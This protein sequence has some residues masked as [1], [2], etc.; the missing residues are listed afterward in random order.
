MPRSGLHA[1]A[2]AF[3]CSMPSMKCAA[4]PAPRTRHARAAPRMRDRSAKAKK[5]M[6][7]PCALPRRA[8]QGPPAWIHKPLVKE[9]PRFVHK[10]HQGEATK[11]AE[12]YTKKMAGAHVFHG[13][14]GARRRRASR[15]GR[16]VFFCARLRT[17]LLPP[18][19]LLLDRRRGLG[20]RAR[21]GK[22]LTF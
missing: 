12:I 11:F 2:M 13:G 19:L 8:L 9:N 10:L 1:A 5:N 14:S 17:R 6:C 3:R 15:L 7:Q 20:S 22:Y 18:L 4:S 21:A 16:G